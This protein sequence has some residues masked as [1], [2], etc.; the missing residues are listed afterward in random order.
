MTDVSNDGE[1]SL[2]QAAAVLSDT[3]GLIDRALAA[4][5]SKT[6]EGDRVSP[7]KLDGYQLV[8]Y[9]LS[10]CWAECSAASFLLAHAGHL[11]QEMPNAAGF[12][13]RLATLFCAEAVTNSAA[14]L[15]AR[16]TDFGLSEVDIS[17][18][19]S[20]DNGAAFLAAQLAAGN[21]A[22]IGQ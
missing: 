22:G 9:E 7:A 15:R 10:L 5:R 17:A 14:R 16:P 13:T 2:A 18:V 11:E 6:L 12:T 8:S 19:T 20:G 4:L 1:R 21:I 3:Q